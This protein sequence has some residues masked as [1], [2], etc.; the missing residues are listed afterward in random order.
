M[1]QQRPVNRKQVS[2]TAS[3]P[4]PVGGWNARDPIGAMAPIDAV[5]LDNYRPLATTVALRAGYSNH[6]TGITG[7]VEALCAYNGVTTNRLFAAAGASIYDVTNLGAV[8]AAV[9]TGQT[10]ARWQHFNV[11]TAGGQFL[12]MVNGVDAP[13]LYNGTTWTAITGVSVPAI[14]GVTTTNL[15]HGNVWKNRVFFVEKSTLKVWYLPVASIAGAASAIDF[16]ALFSRGGYLM[17]MAT[18]TLDAG[19][20]MD[21]HA[22]FITSQGQVAIYKGTDPSSASDFSLVGVYD[23]GSPVGRRCFEK[24]GSD[25]ILITYDGLLPLSKA[26]LSSRVNTGISLTDKIQQAM[27]DAVITSGTNFGWQVSLYPREN[28][29]LL[30]VPVASNTQQF[31]MNTITGAWCRFTNWPAVCWERFNDRLYFG[32]SGK[33]C[34]SF[35]GTNDAGANIAADG[36]Q[37]F[38]NFG[39]NSS[40]KRWV[41]CRPILYSDSPSVGVSIGL[42]VDYDIDPVVNTPSFSSVGTTGLWDS[43]VW[44]SS[45]WGGSLAIRKDWQNLQGVGYSAALRLRTASNVGQ[46][47]WASTDFVLE[48]GGIV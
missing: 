18:W 23:V 20:G 10:S 5:F 9:V 42:G 40:L 17:A 44:D 31:V 48:P 8:G 13:Q 45:T 39:A 12:Y 46:V 33:V 47:Q 26:L 25:L 37:A 30:N 15:I 28:V 3:L 24:F 14:T 7:D 36:L 29:V 16:T 21:D 35:D 6:V 11:S 19:Y 32:T 43:G 27:G 38:S 34:L 1:F 2:R 22:V 41:L 4:A